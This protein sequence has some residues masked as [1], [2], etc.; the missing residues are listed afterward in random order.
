MLVVDDEPKNR[1]LLK[2]LLGPDFNVIEA[3]DGRSALEVIAGEAVDL[4]LL[5]VVMPGLGGYEVCR[6]IKARKGQSFLPVILI[7]VLES[8]EDRK[9]G[10]LAGADDFLTKP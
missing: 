10:F 3:E 4:V 8:E 9:Q 2:A 6:A 7:T 5:D 1:S